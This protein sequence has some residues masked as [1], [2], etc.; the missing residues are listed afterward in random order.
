MKNTLLLNLAVA[1]GVVLY[2]LCFWST[3]NRLP[4]LL[5]SAVLTA[6]ML[7]LHPESWDRPLVRLLT[8]GIVLTSFSIALQLPTW[9]KMVHFA[10]LVVLL[11]FTEG[12]ELRF[13]GIALWLLVRIPIGFLKSI[14][15]MERA[16]GLF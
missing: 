8:F 10:L 4:V 13:L 15:R 7:V 5:F 3:T 6:I 14:F 12:R 9:V 1:V 2:L 11:C 16:S